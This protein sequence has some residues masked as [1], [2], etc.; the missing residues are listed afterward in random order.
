M[1]LMADNTQAYTDYENPAQSVE[2]GLGC[3]A[4]RQAAEGQCADSRLWWCTRDNSNQQ[5]KALY[6]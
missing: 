6:A 2:G 1:V 4:R 5:W 3:D